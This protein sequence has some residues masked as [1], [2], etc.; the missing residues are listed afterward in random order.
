[1]PSDEAFEYQESGYATRYPASGFVQSSGSSKTAAPNA[2]GSDVGALVGRGRTVG[3][4][5]GV[6]RAAADSAAG[7][8]SADGVAVVDA[9]SDAG[10]DAAP[11]AASSSARPRTKLGVFTSRTLRSVDCGWTAVLVGYAGANRG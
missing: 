5:V 1:M 11:Q 7:V 9:G 6:E 2:V 8:D 4:M 3:V 10:T